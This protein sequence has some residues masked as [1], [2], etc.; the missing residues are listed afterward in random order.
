MKEKLFVS[1][2]SQPI[3]KQSIE[4]LATT[5]GNLTTYVTNL[6]ESLGDG[7]PLEQKSLSQGLIKKDEVLSFLFETAGLLRPLH[8]NDPSNN[9]N[10]G[11]PQNDKLSEGLKARG[12]A[13]S[14]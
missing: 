9:Q 2:N 10:E 12:P 14:L 6:L 1:V 8:E 11:K 13:V 4:E 5:K 3:Q 7:A